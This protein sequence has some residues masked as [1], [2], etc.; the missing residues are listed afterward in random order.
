MDVPVTKLRMDSSTNPHLIDDPG[1]II[2]FSG[3]TFGSSCGHCRAVGLT[4]A[5]KKA[6]QSGA[7]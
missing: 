6:P 2:A 1:A 4:T 5:I 7:F 3:E